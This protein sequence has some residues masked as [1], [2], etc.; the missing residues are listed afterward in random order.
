MFDQSQVGVAPFPLPQ[1]ATEVWKFN[2]P[3]GMGLPLMLKTFCEKKF[4]FDN[5]QTV[6]KTIFVTAIIWLASLLY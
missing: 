3:N 2:Q 6:V 4:P 5:M 1:S